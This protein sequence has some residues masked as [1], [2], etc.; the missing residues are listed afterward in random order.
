VSDRYVATDSDGTQHHERSPRRWPLPE[1]TDAGWV[2]GRAVAPDG[3]GAPVTLDADELLAK[4][5]DRIFAAEVLPDGGARLTAGTSWSE[6]QAAC[7]ALDC[8]EHLLPQVPGT[9]GA[10]LPTGDTLVGTVEAAKAYLAGETG[11]AERLGEIARLAASRRLRRDAEE[12]GD[13]ALIEISRDEGDDLEA[14][15]DPIWVT[16][17]A[18]RDAVLAAVEAVRHHAMPGLAEHE[19]RHFEQLEEGK[20][21][22]GRLVESP[23]GSMTIGGAPRYAP[24]WAAARD[25]AERARQ[26]VVEENGPAAGEG[27]RAWQVARL[28]ELLAA[29]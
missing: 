19:S 29:D 23:W 2:A 14:F 10:Q 4:L 24:G 13:E 17:A 26:A 16:L 25:A 9:G 28:T 21:V 11:R 7:F 20:P 18:S 22:Q 27:E 8:V 6:Y 5:G 12:I 15:D 1:R 3:S